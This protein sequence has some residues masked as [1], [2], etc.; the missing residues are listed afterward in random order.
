MDLDQCPANYPLVD[1]RLA[2]WH[3]LYGKLA[4]ANK[5]RGGEVEHMQPDIIGTVAKEEGSRHPY[6]TRKKK[7]REGLP[8]N[9]ADLPRELATQA[10]RRLVSHDAARAE[11]TGA[12]G[13]PAGPHIPRLCPCRRS[14]GYVRARIQWNTRGTQ[15]A[16][17]LQ[18]QPPHPDQACAT[19][20][21][22]TDPR[23][24]V[25]TGSS[26]SNTVGAAAA[27]ASGSHSSDHGHYRHVIHETRRCV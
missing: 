22:E 10:H 2:T 27:S 5:P 12:A 21:Q 17:V 26:T 25:G 13:R 7:K 18:L 6:A 19:G 8:A 11:A 20:G 23:N 14:S 1:L 4:I 16:C 9:G 15:L 3:I 24:T